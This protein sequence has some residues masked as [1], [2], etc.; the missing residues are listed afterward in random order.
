ML[1][2]SRYSLGG[3][4]SNVDK[5]DTKIHCMLKYWLR[6]LVE[7][8]HGLK[9]KLNTCPYGKF[10]GGDHTRTKT[11]VISKVGGLAAFT[12]KKETCIGC[13]T[14]LDKSGNWFNSI[15]RVNS[16]NTID[17]GY[18]FLCLILFFFFFFFERYICF[19]GIWRCNCTSCKNKTC[20]KNR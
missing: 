15:L 8:V 4:V 14:P 5:I 13:K 18:I 12:K 3:K 16:I 9:K 20:I 7:C 2:Y 11:R 10:S 19:H 17:V 1:Y 6:K